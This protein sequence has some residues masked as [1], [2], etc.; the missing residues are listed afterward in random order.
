M[1]PSATPHAHT[2]RWLVLVDARSYQPLRGQLGSDRSFKQVAHDFL[3]YGLT[4]T[5]IFGELNMA[6]LAGLG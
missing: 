6:F 3:V 2:K 1:Q 4:E 5:Y